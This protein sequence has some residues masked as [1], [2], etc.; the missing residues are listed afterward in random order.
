MQEKITHENKAI[1]ALL[2]MLVDDASISDE[3]SENLSIRH[4][5]RE[6]PC[7]VAANS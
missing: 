7:T 6:S 2:N 3:E 5:S 4:I 1:S